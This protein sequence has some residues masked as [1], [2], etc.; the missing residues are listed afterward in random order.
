MRPCQLLAVS[1]AASITAT[2]A[3][4]SSPTQPDPPPPPVPCTFQLT[5]A[6][7]SFGFQGGATSIAVSTAATC[8]WTARSDAEWVVIQSG[9]SGTGPGTI[10][11]TVVAN[12]DAGAREASVSVAEQSVKLTQQ[13]RTPC[14]YAIAPDNARFESDGGTGSITITAASHCA[15]TAVSSDAW[16]ALAAAAGTGDG[17]VT[18]TVSAWTGDA[19]RS[20][21]IRVEGQAV[22]IRQARDPRTCA[23]AVTPVDVVLHWH[24]PGGEIRVTTDADC[25]WT[26]RA[27]ADWLDV[28]GAGSRSGSGVAQF[29]ADPLTADSTRRA[30]V[31]LRWPTP[32]AGQNVWITQEGC[33]YGA[34][35]AAVNV[36]AAGG[37][38]YINV[39]TQPISASCSLGCTWTA[40]PSASWIRV[41]AG[42]PG[43]G[44]DRFRVEIGPNTGGARTGTIRVGGQTITIAQAGS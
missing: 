23:Y 33:R 29:S 44:D 34:Y 39:L 6:S 22:T 43:A 18:Y 40:V 41:A 13:G 1:V 28:S 9:A 2:A 15:W 3:C 20:A 35:P 37:S 17:V 38:E 42:S 27:A 10:A 7:A 21:T 8:A 24:G 16:I 11:V 19:E 36:P 31:E 14:T 4:R 32:S 25:T 5:A 26:V 12:P 30:A